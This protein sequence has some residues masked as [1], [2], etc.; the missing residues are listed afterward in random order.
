[1]NIIALIVAAGESRRFGSELP[2]QYQLLEGKSLLRRSIETYLKH[3]EIS[4]V[5]VVINPAHLEYYAE[6][7]QGLK[8]LPHTSGGST[9]QESVALG[10]KALEQ[11][12]PDYVLIHDAARPNITA[13]LISR[14]IAGLAGTPGVI[15]ALPVFDTLKHVEE[16]RVIGTIERKKLFRAQTPQGFHYQEILNAHRECADLECTDDAAVAEHAGLHIKIVTGSEHNYK[17]TT[18]EDMEDAR[19]LLETEFETRVGTGFDAHRVDKGNNVNICGVSIE[20]GFT[21][22]GHSDADVGL[23]ALV[24]AMLGSMA[25]GDIGMHFPPSDPKWSG[26][27]SALFV[28]HALHLLKERGGKVINADITMIC[29]RPHISPHRERMR[30]RVAGLLEVEASRISIKATTTEKM[31][32][33]GRGEG[34]AAQAVVTVKL[35]ADGK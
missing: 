34:V 22:E 11:T 9:R 10:L 25:A 32:F 3:P 4:G 8:L 30:E 28:T 16:E 12:P 14:V 29:E 5:M 2:K 21:L 26:A 31:G 33:T 1:M 19:R 7:T 23:H 27:D 35:P 13:E 15:P 6:H 24:D 18:M 20:S 17:I